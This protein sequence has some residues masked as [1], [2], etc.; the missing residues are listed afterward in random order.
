MLQILADPSDT[1][2]LYNVLR[3]DYFDLSPELLSQLLVDAHKTHKSLLAWI[4]EHVSDPVT[5][6]LTT[7]QPLVKIVKIIDT[8]QPICHQNPTTEIVHQI[9][10]AFGI[11]T[12]L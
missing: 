4:R 2:S 7:A 10:R 5:G 11:Q 9:V 6:S 1:H 3:S 12:P 8:L